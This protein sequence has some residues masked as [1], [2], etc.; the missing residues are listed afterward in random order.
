MRDQCEPASNADAAKVLQAAKST[1][2]A[3]RRELEDLIDCFERTVETSPMVLTF[4]AFL[5]EKHHRHW[6]STTFV[7]RVSELNKR[8]KAA[9]AQPDV[10]PLG[11]ADHCIQAIP[12]VN[13]TEENPAYQ[14]AWVNKA[15]QS[16]KGL[17]TQTPLPPDPPGPD[18]QHP[19][20][21]PACLRRTTTSIS[22]LE[23]HEEILEA[24]I[25]IAQEAAECLA[26]T[27]SRSRDPKYLSAIESKLEQAPYL[28]HYRVLF[29]PLYS[30]RLRDHL[31]RLVV[32]RPPPGG[33]IYSGMSRTPFT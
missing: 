8:L 31:K 32:L 2:R 21:L 3:N 9:A 5:R 19:K 22:F 12:V 6:R 23:T 15:R 4:T 7:S 24:N 1:V 20:P 27:G 25:H 10:L 16:V 28:R 11:E 14:L 33:Q 29:T 26:T 30:E 17:Y 13:S 18:G